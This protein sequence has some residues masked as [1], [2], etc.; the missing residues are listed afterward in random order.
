MSVKMR[1]K[2]SDLIIDVYRVGSK[3]LLCVQCNVCGANAVGG[4][5]NMYNNEQIC[6]QNENN[7]HDTY[8]HG[9]NLK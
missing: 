4:I 5:H 2:I 7:M 3:I 9:S 1:L 8:V 6:C